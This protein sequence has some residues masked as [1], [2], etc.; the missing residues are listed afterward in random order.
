V[1][2]TA[3][4][5]VY[6][7]VAVVLIFAA[8]AQATPLQSAST[9][10]ACTTAQLS[11]TFGNEGS[12][13]D[14]IFHS[15]TLVFRNI[16]SQTRNVSARP[17]S[18]SEDASST[19]LPISLETRTGMHLCPVSLSFAIPAIAKAAGEIHLVSG[20]IDNSKCFTPA[21]VAITLG[22]DVL[23]GPFTGHL[24][25]PSGQDAKYR[26]AYLKRDPVYVRSKS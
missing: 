6:V 16:G 23:R 18:V 9:L 19:T 1:N 12:D 26:F 13:F 14:R 8:S 4:N 21:S 3:S 22:A 15:G 17:S 5:A 11:L 10:L 20:Q 24:C 2:K 7:V 25:A